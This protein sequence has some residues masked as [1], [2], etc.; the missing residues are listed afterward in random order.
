[1]RSD[2]DREQEM[3]KGKVSGDEVVGLGGEGRGGRRVGRDT[4]SP[5][6]GQECLQVDH[7]GRHFLV[8]KSFL[9]PVFFL[10]DG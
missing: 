6:V 7:A 8:L 5:S 2:R 4:R 9:H 3:R 1:M 10:S